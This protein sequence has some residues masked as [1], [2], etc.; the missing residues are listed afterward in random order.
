MSSN[1]ALMK[2]ELHLFISG[3]VQGVSYRVNAVRMASMLSLTGWVRNLADG[4]VEALAQGEE[5]ALRT[6]LAWAHHGPSQARVDHVETH[7]NEGLEKLQ[8]FQIR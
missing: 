3:Q 4:R 7:W 8:D 1:P 2:T 6:F 5:K